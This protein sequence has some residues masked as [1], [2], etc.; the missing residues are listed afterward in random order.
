MDSYESQR[1][2][3]EAEQQAYWK[4]LAK[5]LERLK[6]ECGASMAELADGLKISKQPLY[7]FMQKPVD[8]LKV[9]RA[10]LCGLWA[11]LIDPDQYRSRKLREEHKEAR[12][13]LDAHGPDSLLKAAGYLGTNDLNE[14]VIQVRDPYLKKIVL[15]LK[16]RWLYDDVQRAQII[17]RFLDSLLDEGRPDRDFHFTRLDY[18]REKDKQVIM[19][20]PF[21]FELQKKDEHKDKVKK[22]YRHAIENLVAFGKT[23]FVKAELFE[24]Y[25][26]ILEHYSASDEVNQIRIYDCAFETISTGSILDDVGIE[27]VQIRA[28]KKLSFNPDSIVSGNPLP[29]IIEVKIGCEFVIDDD[30]KSPSRSYFKYTSSNTHVENMIVA[31]K[32]G[33]CLSLGMSGFFLKTVGRTD[34]SL[35][36]IAI[37]LS[38]SNLYSSSEDIREAY[39]GWWVTSNTVI[40]ILKAF[41]DAFK[42]WLNSNRIPPNEY[43]WAC[44]KLSFINE[45]F[46]KI[47]SSVYE[48]NFE[49]TPTLDKMKAR[50]NEVVSIA[51]DVEARELTPHVEEVKFRVRAKERR[52]Q[53]A[54]LH[55]ALYQGNLKE[56]KRLLDESESFK[57]LTSSEVASSNNQHFKNLLGMSVNSALM[58]YKLIS[59]DEEFLVGRRW[60]VEPNF[61]VA[62]CERVADEYI[63]KS[64]NINF[65]AY[66]FMSDFFSTLGIVEFYG[67][68]NVR[69]NLEIGLEYVLE[70]AH[71]SSRIG[72]ERRAAEWLMYAVRYFSRIKSKDAVAKVD[73]IVVKTKEIL[74]GNQSMQNKDWLNAIYHLGYGESLLLLNKKYA[75]ALVEFLLALKC[76]LEIG[77]IRLVPDCLYDVFRAC[78]AIEKHDE[79]QT[80][81]SALE[82]A[83]TNEKM[84]EECSVLHR[85]DD[86]Y[87]FIL[88]D[89]VKKCFVEINEFSLSEVKEVCRKAAIDMWNEWAISVGNEKHTFAEGIERMIFISPLDEN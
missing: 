8:G 83:I 58:R 32:E 45:L 13:T 23:K 54:L 15:R 1:Q 42:G 4:S 9:R 5:E 75:E 57:E 43:Y 11:Y 68:D 84:Y 48:G 46:Y 34:K 16:S 86:R 17:D 66:Y 7:N 51:K 2:R 59:G 63:R 39:Q 44:Q 65:N 41:V 33:L 29:T 69:D 72:Y 49:A 60:R 3:F 87:K 36:R 79:N 56:A 31:I 80:L 61:S 37:A 19:E 82:T 67:S 40:G 26:S 38:D 77:Y 27:G 73:R 50:I 52:L 22:N 25:Q 62:E 47:N 18:E 74:D 85:M 78:Y 55:L 81:N 53:L 88:K 64:G 89:V 30:L 20:W 76:S 35:V 12:K 71:F 21:S 70:A 10:D 6:D 14:D 28:E 24:L